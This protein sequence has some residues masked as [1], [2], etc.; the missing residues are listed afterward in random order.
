M[1]ILLDILAPWALLNVTVC[2]L[3]CVSMMSAERREAGSAERDLDVVAVEHLT[4]GSVRLFAR[5]DDV[6]KPACAR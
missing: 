5:P 2:G 1:N 4:A 3:A 6:C